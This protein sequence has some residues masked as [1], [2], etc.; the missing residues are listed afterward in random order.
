MFY[1]FVL[2][3]S[4]FRV[5]YSRVAWMFSWRS[6]FVSL[7]FKE[8]EVDRPPTLWWCL[9]LYK[10]QKAKSASALAMPSKYIL[11]SNKGQKSPGQIIN[12]LNKLKVCIPC[13]CLQRMTKNSNAR[14]QSHCTLCRCD[15]FIIFLTPENQINV[16]EWSGK[17]SQSKLKSSQTESRTENTY[18]KKRLLRTKTD[19]T[20]FHYISRRL[21]LRDCE[22][23]AWVVNVVN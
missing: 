18:G 2:A 17:R 1:C 11:S 9:P 5:Y 13:R 22:K 10:Y 21:F 7:R 6:V 16:I 19:K 23:V 15:C 20:T 8:K 3:P 4:F 14:V 12:K